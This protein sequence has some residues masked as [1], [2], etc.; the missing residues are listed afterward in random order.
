MDWILNRIGITEP[1]HHSG[2]AARAGTGIQ[3]QPAQ[4]PSEISSWL[5]TGKEY[6]IVSYVLFLN[7]MAITYNMWINTK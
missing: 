2:G 1:D 3:W 4:T 5:Q 7:P 6:N